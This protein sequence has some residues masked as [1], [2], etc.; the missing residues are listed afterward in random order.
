[1]LCY[2][3]VFFVLQLYIFFFIWLP[4]MFTFGAIICLLIL[5]RIFR[6]ILQVFFSNSSSLIQ[7]YLSPTYH[8]SPTCIDKANNGVLDGA[9]L[10]CCQP[11]LKFVKIQ[12]FKI[13]N[14]IRT[15][16]SLCKHLETSGYK[17]DSSKRLKKIFQ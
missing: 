6:T 9:C 8:K 15:H 13:S 7:P 11:V 16:Q 14:F 5:L 3:A 17:R 4:I 10:S 2:I 12:L 1:M